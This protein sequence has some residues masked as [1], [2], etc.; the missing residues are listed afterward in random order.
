MS[1]LPEGT[2]VDGFPL[3]A[4]AKV[5]GKQAIVDDTT[6]ERDFGGAMIIQA[7]SLEE[8][9]RIAQSSPHVS[10]GGKILVK[11]FDMM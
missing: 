11:P 6:G 9:L 4:V 10:M 7:T 1:H 2:V 8:A 5:V 3:E